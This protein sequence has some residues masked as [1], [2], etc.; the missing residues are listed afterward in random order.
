MQSPE[1]FVLAF[2]SA[3]NALFR[4]HQNELETFQKEFC[5]DRL[6]YDRRLAGY[7]DERILNVDRQGTKAEITTN[8]NNKGVIASRLRYVLMAVDDAWIISDLQFECPICHGTGKD[9]SGGQRGEGGT[10]TTDNCRS[11]KGLKW[12]STKG[13]VDGLLG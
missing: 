4:R 9:P 1:A 7:E 6:I 13:A 10:V 3:R 8:G 12:I 5:Q 11:C 2:F